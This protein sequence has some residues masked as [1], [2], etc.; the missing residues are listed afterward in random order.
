MALA[1]RFVAALWLNE[2]ALTEQIIDELVLARGGREPA[3]MLS[4]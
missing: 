3:A 4:G 1:S 2:W